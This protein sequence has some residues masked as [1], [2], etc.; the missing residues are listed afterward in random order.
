M[1]LPDGAVMLN[2][3][4][5]VEYMAP[6]GHI[7]IESESYDT[8]NEDIELPKVL[9]LLEFVK[10]KAVAP[11]LAQLVAHYCLESSGE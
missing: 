5:V 6:D 7:Y 4:L 1:I 3:L 8:A 11:M 9:E 2:N 10:A